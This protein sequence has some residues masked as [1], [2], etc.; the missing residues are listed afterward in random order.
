[1][2]NVINLTIKMLLVLIFISANNSL[3]AAHIIGAEVSYKHISGSEYQFTLKVFRDCNECKFNGNGGGSSTKNCNEVPDLKIRGALN[4]GYS[5]VEFGDVQMV[6]TKITD[7]TPACY[8]VSGTCS[9]NSGILF[10][11]EMH[12]FEGTFNFNDLLLSGKCEFDVSISMSS[13]N[14]NINSMMAEQN[15]FNYTYLNLC[16]GEIN[17]STE[18]KSSPVFALMQNQ[19]NAIALGIINN[20]KDSLSFKLKPALVNRNQNVVYALGKT[21]SQP[22]TPY[23]PNFP[24]CTPNPVAAQPE[25]FFVSNA[26]GDIVF[27]PTVLNEGGVTVVECEEWKLNTDGTRYLAGVTRRDIYSEVII[28]SNNLPRLKFNEIKIDLCEGEVFNYKINIEDPRSFPANSD[29]VT[30]KVIS[31]L[32]GLLLQKDVFNTPP[33]NFYM[34]QLGN[35]LNLKGKHYITIVAS[36]NNCPVRGVISKTIVLNFKEKQN[37]S[38]TY[39]TRNCG[40]LQVDSKLKNPEIRWVLYDMGMNELKKQVGVGFTHQLSSGGKYILKAV[41]DPTATQC[42]VNRLDTITVNNF[43]KPVFEMGPDVLVCKGEKVN[44]TPSKLTTFDLYKIIY[45]NQA[46]IFPLDYTAVNNKRLGFRAI[47]DDGCYT[48]A[49]L[50][51]NIYPELIIGTR[52][53]T[54]CSNFTGLFDVDNLLLLDR[55]KAS[56]ID[57]ACLDNSVELTKVDALNWQLKITTPKTVNLN[58]NASITDVNGCKYTK[59]FNLAMIEPLPITLKLP[60]ELCKNSTALELPVN[61]NGVWQCISH[62]ASLNNGKLIIAND[63][64]GPVKLVYT[65]NNQCINSKSYEIELNDSTTITMLLGKSK[66]VCENSQPIALMAEPSGGEWQGSFTSQNIFNPESAKNTTNELTYKYTNQ[67]GC[68]SIDRMTIVVVGLPTLSV[69]S[70]SSEICV[71]DELAISATTDNSGLSGYWFSTGEGRFDQPDHLKSNYFPSQNDVNSPSIR[72][73]Y[74]LQTNSVCGNVTE[75]IDIAVKAGPTGTIVKDYPVAQCEPASLR[76]KTNFQGIDKQLWYINDSLVESYI[77]TNDLESTLGAGYYIIKTE[78][79]NSLCKAVALSDTIE[80]YSRPVTRFAAN[81][82]Q[83]ISREYPRIY[84]KEMTKNRTPF[85]TQWYYNNLPIS[86]DKEVYYNVESESDTFSIKLIN[87]SIAGGCADSLTKLFIFNPIN[88]LYVPNVFTPDAKGPEE[89]N[90]FKI[91]GPAMNYFYIEIFNKWGEKVFYSKDMNI[92]WDGTCG[93]K[94]CIQGVYYYKINST[95]ANGVSRDYSGTVTLI[96]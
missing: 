91:K 61:K 8:G 37:F 49:Y 53:D 2:K 13:R 12:E 16:K 58:F 87:Y 51:V 75:G 55:S 70:K 11:Y 47:Q 85:T 81:P 45:N 7:L 38:Y 43:Q 62:P 67:K 86:Q 60:A 15:F 95:D 10:G 83:K 59:S 76:F 40:L 19:P 22:F 14:S 24:I 52:V 26:T 42:G 89:N 96:R 35:T 48:D 28:N 34:L 74:T 39:R 44:I 88:Q 32:S 94:L 57:I 31:S 23:C 25:G 41:L 72:I 5:N 54:I 27:T 29:S 92:S 64:V 33:Y 1:M 71:G 36:D 46:I 66:T 93:G 90:E 50:N 68:V 73:S 80:I 30:V 63:M 82:Q 3:W 9:N 77:Y 56:K 4:S 79:F 69:D 17:Q 18:F 78:V 65:E 21:Y 84:L 6:R 20:D